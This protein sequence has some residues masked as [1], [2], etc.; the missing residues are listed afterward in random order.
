MNNQAQTHL[1]YVDLLNEWDP[2]EL[3]NGDYD[4]EI[5]D[6]IQAI[7]ECDNAEALAKKIQAIYE[8]SF[9]KLIPFEGCLKIAEELLEVKNNE[10]C[11]LG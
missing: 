11:S 9:E 7:H 8:F 1:L 5:A 10:S 6:T 3:I 2:F 4:P